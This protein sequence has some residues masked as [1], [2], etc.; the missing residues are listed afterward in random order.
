MKKGHCQ[1]LW[2]RS[3]GSFL[4]P[5]WL[6]LAQTMKRDEKKVMVVPEY[7]FEERNSLLSLGKDIVDPQEV[8]ISCHL[9]A[10]LVGGLA[11]LAF[12]LL[13]PLLVPLLSSGLSLSFLERKLVPLFPPLSMLG[14]PAVAVTRE[15]RLGSRIIQDAGS[16]QKV[17]VTIFPLPAFTQQN[18]SRMNV[19]GI[20]I[21]SLT[22]GWRIKSFQTLS[23]SVPASPTAAA[24]AAALTIKTLP[25]HALP[26]RLRTSP[27]KEPVIPGPIQPPFLLRT[28]LYPCSTKTREVLGN[29]SPTPER[30]PETRGK[31]RG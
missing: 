24:A 23:V 31:S 30:Y 18:L 6:T 27:A 5:L 14:L 2:L 7:D 3:N 10:A 15:E 17:C 20:V 13:L 16:L 9:V 4:D 19:G 28:A 29:P 11:I 21:S 22:R 12:Q 8:E 25:R 1:P 26:P